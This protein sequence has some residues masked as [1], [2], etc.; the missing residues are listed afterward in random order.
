MP[1]PLARARSLL[2]AGRDAEA[3]VL[4]Q[5]PTEGLPEAERLALLGFLEARRGNLEAYR[6][7]ALLAVRRAQTPT[8]L[9]HLGLALSPRE[10]LLILEEALYRTPTPRERGRLA[11]ALART[12]RRLGRLRE[13]LAYAALARLEDAGPYALLEWAWLALLSEET[14][15]LP[16]LLHLVEP[17]ASR[18]GPAL[19]ARFLMA[20]LRLLQGEQELARAYFLKALEEAPPPALPYLAPAR[21]RLLGGEALPLLQAAW[22]WAGEEPTRSLVHLAEGLLQEDREAVAQALPRLLEGAG[23]EALR[24]LLFLGEAHPLLGELSQRGRWFLWPTA[25]LPHLQ[26]LGEARLDSQPLPLRQ[27]ELLVLLLARPEGWT[28]EA[29]ALALYGEAN[30][31]TLRMEIHRLRQRGQNILARPYRLQNALRADFLEV[32]AALQ[33]G[34]LKEALQIYRGPLLPQSGAP[35]VE[36]LRQELEEA[37]RQAVLASRDPEALLLLAEHLGEDLELWEAL[38]ESLPPQDPRRPFVLAR[39]A[40]LRREWG[41]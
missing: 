21:V 12:L 33:R 2:E 26:V 3:E 8:T 36:E 31:P 22:P 11:L 29:L 9:Y 24:A 34:D 7:L 37:L 32:R 23:E 39:T 15:S 16:E 14:P 19:Y 30:G 25:A 40:R 6:T 35:A 1:D 20:H 28:G 13:A 4:L 41:L 17:L 5:S 38:L 27:A 18:E 10:G